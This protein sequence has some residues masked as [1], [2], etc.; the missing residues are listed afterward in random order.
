[1]RTNSDAEEKFNQLKELDKF[2]AKLSS[3]KTNTT[4]ISKEINEFVCNGGFDSAN[5]IVVELE[6]IGNELKEIEL[7]IQNSNVLPKNYREWLVD[8]SLGVKGQHD[9]RTK[10]LTKG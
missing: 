4:D 6:N 3:T 8:F 1:M 2:A 5:N 10:E 9:R 7:Q